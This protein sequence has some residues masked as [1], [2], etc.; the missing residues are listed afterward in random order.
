L[1]NLLTQQVPA[2]HLLALSHM[3]WHLAF[4][5]MK[6]LILGAGARPLGLPVLALKVL[7]QLNPKLK[8]F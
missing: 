3:G 6:Q 7:T 5:L 2:I 1:L 8:K 4:Q